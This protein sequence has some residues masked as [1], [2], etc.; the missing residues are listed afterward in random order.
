[1]ADT[2][3]KIQTGLETVD[4]F[5]WYFQVLVCIGVSALVIYSLRRFVLRKIAESFNDT[6]AGW[7]NDLYIAL[8]S[9]VSIF[10]LV[11]CIH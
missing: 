10:F 6:E 8:E 9:K 7:D 4:G 3:E 2:I 5:D 11:I 1:M